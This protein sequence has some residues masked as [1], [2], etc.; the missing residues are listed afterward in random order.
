MTYR[1]QASISAWNIFFFRGLW[2]G[3]P[4]LTPRLWSPLCDIWRQWRKW[5]NFLILLNPLY[6]LA[7]PFFA[8]RV[9]MATW[10]W[11][12][13]FFSN[14]SA[15]TRVQKRRTFI[16]KPND[17]T[18]KRLL[19]FVPIELGTRNQ[20]K[21]ETLVGLFPTSLHAGVKAARFGHNIEIK[22]RLSFFFLCSLR[23]Y[24]RANKN[25]ALCT[26]QKPSAKWKEEL[27]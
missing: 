21:K 16:D 14:G 7:A 3:F 19:V 20:R 27:S 1:S 5:V 25:A 11:P 10:P 15:R 13:S 4:I 24:E 6:T 26:V 18:I 2:P 12:Q 17:N 9:W 23:E 22:R 8:W